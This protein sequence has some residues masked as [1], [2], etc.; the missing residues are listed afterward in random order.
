MLVIPVGCVDIEF[1][2]NKGP[3]TYKT[4]EDV[5]VSWHLNYHPSKLESYTISVK[6]K[7]DTENAWEDSVVLNDASPGEH[8]P[9]DRSKN[10][11]KMAEG[12]YIAAFT[13]KPNDNFPPI[14]DYGIF[15]VTPSTG[16]IQIASFYDANGNGEKDV[17]EGHEGTEFKITGTKGPDYSAKTG[18][19]GIATIKLPIGQYTITELP[20]NCWRSI[21]GTSQVANVVEDRTT[22][23]AFKDEPDTGYTIFGYND[24]THNGIAG[25]TFNVSGPEGTQT[26]ASGSDGF[27]RPLRISL[28]GTHTVVAT[29]PAGMEMATPGQIEFDPCAQKQIEFGANIAK[30]PFSVVISEIMDYITQLGERLFELGLSIGSLLIYLII[31]LL[32]LGLI[33]KYWKFILRN[34]QAILRS[35]IVGYIVTQI[36]TILDCIWLFL[37]TPFGFCFSITYGISLAAFKLD[38]ALIQSV[39]LQIPIYILYGLISWAVAN[40][41]ATAYNRLNPNRYYQSMAYKSTDTY[42]YSYL[43]NPKAK[44]P[45]KVLWNW[46]SP[47]GTLYET[48]SLDIGRDTVSCHCP[49]QIAGKNA[50]N[51]IG[52]WHVD[53]FINGKKILT[54]QFAL[55]NNGMDDASSRR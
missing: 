5:S 21:S 17:G 35:T 29:P 2:G 28:P 16:S 15:V 19:D 48:K 6:N 18:S 22:S 40:I 46:Y 1:S 43:E 33:I 47:N 30:P 36:K 42:A 53:I 34:W 31:A 20:S 55:L 37:H 52:T 23:V 13:S 9:I 39:P 51:L 54:E 14:N 11:G 12:V 50:A 38:P 8:S 10:L 25:F 4:N 32:I 24:S 41:L 49:I 44:G 7:E 3:Y 26:L 27:A 45:A